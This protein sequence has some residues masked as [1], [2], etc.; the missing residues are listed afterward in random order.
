MSSLSKNNT[1]DGPPKKQ[2][3]KSQS[4]KTPLQNRSPA[5]HEKLLQI[6]TFLTFSTTDSDETVI[7]ALCS[8]V[9]TLDHIDFAIRSSTDSTSYSG[10]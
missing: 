1:L 8:R 6:R 9:A 4:K 2:S 10:P 3:R 5:G 7:Y